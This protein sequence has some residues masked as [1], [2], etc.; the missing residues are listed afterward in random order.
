MALRA[1]I[2]GPATPSGARAR[3]RPR[4]WARWPPTWASNA[5]ACRTSRSST[6]MNDLLHGVS[7]RASLATVELPGLPPFRME[8]HGRS[9]VFVSKAIEDFGIWDRA[10]T[11]AVLQLLR[12]PIDFVDVGANIG[13]F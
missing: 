5:G 13:W 1:R 11:A 10:V 9:D 7:E 12:S 4:G 6:P 2:S 3:S 8:T